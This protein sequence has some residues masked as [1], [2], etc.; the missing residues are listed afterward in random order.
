MGGFESFGVFRIFWGVSNPFGGVSNILVCFESFGGVSN[1]LGVFRIF[2][3]MF[4]INRCNLIC[5]LGCFVTPGVQ[6]FFGGCFAHMGHRRK[7]HCHS[8][9][10]YRHAIVIYGLI[11][12]LRY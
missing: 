3:G 9:L 4:Q 12:H 11:A 5:I 6:Y 2:W 1:L 10:A 8:F 7:Q